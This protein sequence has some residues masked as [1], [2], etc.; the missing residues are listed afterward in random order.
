MGFMNKK[1]QAALLDS[2]FFLTIVASISAG[3]L[4]FTINYG[5]QTQEQMSSFYS[6][7][8]CADALKIITYINVTRQGD[9]VSSENISSSNSS[10]IEL[11]YL[12]AL[13]KEDYADKK[14]MSQR[15]KNALKNTLES[16]L[17]PFEA[18][19][20]YVYYLFD[21]EP[22]GNYLFLLFAVHECEGDGCI[23]ATSKTKN[24]ERVFYFCTPQG[25]TDYLE[26]DLFPTLGKVDSAFG[27]ISLPEIYAPSTTSSTDVREKFFI[28]GLHVWVV[29][30]STELK[31]VT[32]TNTDL[33]CV[34]IP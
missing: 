13:I 33:N 26:K 30:N 15:T 1:G 29:K 8:F 6:T 7:D 28:M 24:V 18:S 20:D 34:I 4:F 3:L 5:L 32:I 10:D 27:K 9:N 2:I 12:L 31:K 14:E 23:D 25:K 16:A 22:S 17:K 21:N 11:D 19:I